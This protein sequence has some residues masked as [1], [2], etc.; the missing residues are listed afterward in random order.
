[1]LDVTSTSVTM[2]Q[3][4]ATVIEVKEMSPYAHPTQEMQEALGAGSPM[5]RR[6]GPG[7]RLC[8]HRGTREIG[9]TWVELEAAG[10]RIIL[11]HG[12]PLDASD[13]ATVP[14]LDVRGL[15]KPDASLLAIVLSHGHRDHWGLCRRCVPTSRL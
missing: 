4:Q 1:M 5:A 14:L 6:Q 10:V 15:T 8:I 11:D 13:R 2:C 12:L 3:W 7:M 9:G